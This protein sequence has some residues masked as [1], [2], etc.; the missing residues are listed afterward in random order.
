M[1]AAAERDATVEEVRR[2]WRDGRSIGR[3]YRDPSGSLEA[4]VERDAIRFHRVSGQL[5]DDLALDRARVAAVAR[6]LDRWSAV[7]DGWAWYEEKGV[8]PTS[9]AVRVHV[10]P[11]RDAP[12]RVLGWS[13]D[14]P[15][16]PAFHFAGADE[17]RSL[18][19]P[20]RVGDGIVVLADLWRVEP[21]VGPVGGERVGER[22]ALDGGLVLDV[23]RALALLRVDGH[24][25]PWLPHE[26]TLPGELLRLR[27]GAR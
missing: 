18:P 26:A 25:F 12:R 22:W 2:A 4:R 1:T 17:L 23:R 19:A 20:R 9:V 14:Q 8:P 15:G 11:G 7:R 13:V 3:V 16:R 21:R 10:A 27:G 6:A 24:W 5:C